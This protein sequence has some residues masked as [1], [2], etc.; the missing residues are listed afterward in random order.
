MPSSALLTPDAAMGFQATE[1]RG[2]D[3]AAPVTVNSDHPGRAPTGTA[4]QRVASRVL[5]SPVLV[6][7]SDPEA[8]VDYRLAVHLSR[9]GRIDYCRLESAVLW[10]G[11]QGFDVETVTDS[12]RDNERAGAFLLRKFQLQIN[13]VLQAANQVQT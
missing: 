8:A 4:G 3:R 7:I 11:K 2:S 9:R 12:P 10:I 13:A 5:Q 6:E 1:S